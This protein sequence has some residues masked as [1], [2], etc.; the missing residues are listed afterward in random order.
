LD[1]IV[2][3][4]LS[5]AQ[6][7]QLTDRMGPLCI[8]LPAPEVDPP[9]WLS[10]ARSVISEKHRQYV[11]DAKLTTVSVGPPSGGGLAG[12]IGQIDPADTSFCWG[13][14]VLLCDLDPP[15]KA[16]HPRSRPQWPASVDTQTASGRW[17]KERPN[18]SA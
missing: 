16:R 17:P 15:L 5:S 12:V 8:A 7:K 11:T 1:L 14:E 13:V 2:I 4:H 10:W 18:A 6:H 9:D 3:Y